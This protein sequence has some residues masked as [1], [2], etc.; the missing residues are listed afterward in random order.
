MFE[1]KK[2]KACEFVYIP[3]KSSLLSLNRD[4]EVESSLPLFFT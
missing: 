3:S 1:F 4:F 2:L